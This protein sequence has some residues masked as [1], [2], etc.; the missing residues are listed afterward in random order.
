MAQAPITTIPPFSDAGKLPDCAKQ[1]GPLYDANG[2]CVPPAAPEAAAS[3]Y[4]ACFCGH[5]KVSPFS[6][7]PTGVCDQ[8]CQ[9]DQA[10]LQSIA[11][12]FR[13]ICSAQGDG[14]ANP[15]NGQSTT[16][17][18][19]NGS[20]KQTSN[21]TSNAGGGDWLSNHWQW[22]IMIVVL[23]VGIAAIW[24][25]ACVWRRRY[26]RKKDSPMSLGQK[27][28]GSASNPSWGPAVAGSESATPMAYGRDPEQSVPE[29][30]KKK[31][32]KKWTVGRRT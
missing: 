25:G 2:A 14:A 21:T 11:N 4:T 1:C 29:K 19:N 18:G 5:A 17:A 6:K 24:I 32:K 20:Q 7:G 23:V 12:W 28:S 9:G 31:E 16:S 30:P 15:Q 22:V 3:A 10:G 27:H 13:G 26:L 8:A